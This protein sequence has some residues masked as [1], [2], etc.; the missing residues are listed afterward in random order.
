MVQ[1]QNA[2]VE[3]ASSRQVLFVDYDGTLHRFGA[4]RTRRGIVSS[5]PGI[6]LFEFAALLAELLG[7][8]PQVDIVL[9]T[10]WVRAFGFR[11]ARKALPIDSLRQRVV[12]ATFHSR[13][14]DA[15]AWPAIGRGVQILRYVR[16]HGLSRWVAIDDEDD[17][18]E[19]EIEHLVKCDKR[20]ALGDRKTHQALQCR[21]AE[22]FGQQRKN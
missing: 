19:E 17:G 20:F 14:P 1:S 8:Y 16:A 6:Q 2:S 5:D 13:F 18:F 11:Q 15:L 4:Y 10:S 3:V 21:L 7:P 22:Q 9:S 12:G